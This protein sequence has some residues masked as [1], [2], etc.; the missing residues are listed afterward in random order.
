M[1]KMMDDDDNNNNLLK[2]DESLKELDEQ[3]E[4]LDLVMQKMRAEWEESGAGIGWMRDTLHSPMSNTIRQSSIVSNNDHNSHFYLIQTEN[5]TNSNLEPSHDYL[6]A[7]LNVNDEL[8]AESLASTTTATFNTTIMNNDI[9]KTVFKPLTTTSH[10]TKMDF[11][12]VNDNNQLPISPPEQEEETIKPLLSHQ[13]VTPPVTPPE[14][15]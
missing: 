10:K 8:L 4:R 1:T 13:F 9:P 7:L 14:E 6:Q 15:E 5:N 11:V 12:V 3:R 2:Y